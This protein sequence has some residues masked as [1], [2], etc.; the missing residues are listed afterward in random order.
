M[1]SPLSL[2]RP[3][4]NFCQLALRCLVLFGVAVTAHAQT[5]KDRDRL[6]VYNHAIYDSAVYKFS[7]LRP[8]LP[9]KFEGTAKTAKVVSLTPYV[10]YQPGETTLTREVWVTGFPEVQN[11]CRTFKDDLEMNLREL[12]GLTP[13][14]MFTYFVTFEVR[15]EDVFRP[16]ANPDPTT[17]LPCGYPVPANCGEA[18][19]DVVPADHVK[20]F[21]DKMLSSYVIA[22]STLINTG[23]PWTRLGYTYNWRPGSNKYGASEYVI[24]SGKTVRVTEIT[25]Y[26]T[27]CAPVN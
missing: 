22:E 3:C 26:K 19:P 27:Y 8:L 23:Y 10:G 1:S 5:D 16:T 7:N 25:P 4:K 12:L 17:T 14:S 9:L 18:F 21:A 20:W 11:I 15:Q 13:T 2:M 6:G 24:R